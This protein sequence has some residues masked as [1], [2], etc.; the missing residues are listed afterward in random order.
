MMKVNTSIYAG[1]LL[2]VWGYFPV[3]GWACDPVE[4]GCLG[5]SDTELAVCIDQFVIEVCSAGGGFEYC[6]RYDAAEDIERLVLRSTGMH[7]S[8]VRAL[9]RGAKRYQQPRSPRP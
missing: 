5:C 9:I 4:D 7:M 1:V 2:L 6:D 3:T 8:K